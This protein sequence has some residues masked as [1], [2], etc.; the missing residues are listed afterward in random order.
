[1]ITKITFGKIVT[2]FFAMSLLALSGG[3]LADGAPADDWSTLSEKKQ[4]KLGLYMTAEQAYKMTMENM[5]KTLFLD[6]RT[7]SELNY[8]GAPTVMDAHVP[9]V[10]MDTTAWN[11][12]KHRYKRAENKNFVAD[13]D[14]QLKKKGLTKADT[15]VLMCR[16]GKRSATAVNVLAD[17]GYTR[18]FSVVD[19][20]EGD[21][22]KEGDHK[23]QRTVNGWKNS[24]LPWTYSLDRDY[25]YFTR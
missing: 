23:G 7:P 19:G 20:Y 18:V 9:M 3:V 17:A 24:G 11:D 14:A 6:I 13:V 12:K 10:F 8:L 4:N 1:M 22:A 25:M 5:D 21:K 16:S 15:V 2:A